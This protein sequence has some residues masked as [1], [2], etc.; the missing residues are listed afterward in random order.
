MNPILDSLKGLSAAA[1]EVLPLLETHD[2]REE[3]KYFKGAK[4]PMQMMPK[5]I[6]KIFKSVM[7]YIIPVMDDDNPLPGEALLSIDNMTIFSD[8]LT[9]TGDT[10]LAHQFQF[11]QIEPIQTVADEFMELGLHQQATLLENVCRFARAIRKAHNSAP[12]GNTGKE[13]APVHYVLTLAPK[14]MNK[15]EQED[16]ILH[17]IHNTMN[18]NIEI[19]RKGFHDIRLHYREI[20]HQEIA[21]LL[22]DE[23][24]LP[25]GPVLNFG[26]AI[27]EIGYEEVGTTD[28]DDN[29]HVVLYLLYGIELKEENSLVFHWRDEDCFDIHRDDCEPDVDALEDTLYLLNAILKD[30]ESGKLTINENFQI[31]PTDED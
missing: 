19:L 2:Y 9:V 26:Q 10:Q 11:V 18:K 8:N 31:L 13:L 3:A 28:R 16:N 17:P 4:M 22:K 30:I 15:Q 27:T 25:A 1:S 6:R 7:R 24:H 12:F 20:L 29:D 14:E 23:F 5:T 21:R